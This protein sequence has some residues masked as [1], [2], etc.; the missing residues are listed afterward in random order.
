[1]FKVARAFSY[2]N[3]SSLAKNSRNLSST[4]ENI[5]FNVINNIGLVTLNRPN[6]Y[7]ALTCAMEKSLASK[8]EQFSQDASIQAILVKGSGNRAFSAGGDL[9]E[10][11]H[12][13]KSSEIF[14]FF[15]TEYKLVH[16]IA[17]YSKPYISI[18]NGITM[19]AGAGISMHGKYRIATEKTLF[20]M[21]ETAIGYIADVGF[22]IFF[23]KLPDNISLFMGLT[24]SQIRGKDVR[25][26]GIAT[27]FVNEEDLASLE[28]DLFASKNVGDDLDGILAKY[29]KACEGIDAKK[30]LINTCIV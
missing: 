7:N 30:I 4:S 6:Q 23:Q 10:L 17:N 11:A 5:Q 21:P 1:M 29:D 19:G 13:S 12:S 24:G 14:D 8:L 20:A 18:W 16:Q 2:A 15:R 26:L 3:S 22:Y 9:K 27:H 28:N 25:R